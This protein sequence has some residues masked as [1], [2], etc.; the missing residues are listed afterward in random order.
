MNQ[1]TK[2]HFERE[3]KLAY[4]T[5]KG[6]DFQNWFADI[7]ELRFS[8]DF[9]RTRPWGC[10]GDRKNDGY[11]A[12]KR[13]LFQ[14][15]APERIVESKAL[16]KINEDFHGAKQYWKSHFDT[17]VFV[18]NSD[19]GLTP[20]VLDRLLELNDAESPTVKSWG[21]EELYKVVFELT[22]TELR[23]LFEGVPN[24]ADIY[25]VKYENFKNVLESVARKS[26]VVDSEIQQVPFGK[27]DS[28]G[29]SDESK[30]FIKLGQRKS[31]YAGQFFRQWYDPRYGEEISASF[32][33]E[34]RRLKNIGIP[35][36]DIYSRLTLFTGLHRVTAPQDKMAV[37]ALVAY[38]FE[39]CDIFENPLEETEDDSAN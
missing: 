2:F 22:E 6:N 37:Y 35:P 5:K 10:S 8:G 12:S 38:F 26:P 27:L 28:N 16:Q 24:E 1:I 4:L 9:I 33:E 14:V 36:D 17:W 23:R 25:D 3:F 31:K 30:H 34:Y 18:H 32:K 7:M 19:Q 21:R 11:L 20:K 29:L 15:Y 39:V 13:I